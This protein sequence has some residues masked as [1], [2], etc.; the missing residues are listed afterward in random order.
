MKF[1]I[2][3]LALLAGISYA[4]AAELPSGKAQPTTGVDYIKVCSA[5]GEGFFTLP[6]SDTCVKISGLV[7]FE[8]QYAPTGDLYKVTSG[9]KAVANAGPGEASTGTTTT[10]I[11]GI[12]T[13]TPTELGDIRTV[14]DVKIVRVSGTAS[15]AGQ[16]SGATQSAS[17]TSTGS[18][19][20][21]YIQ[22][23]GFTGGIA[24]DNFK[25]MSRVGHYL[26]TP[27]WPSFSNG[28][29]Q[30][31]Y[32]ALFGGGFS[33][34]LA[35]Q[36]PS[37][38]NNAPID[39][40]TPTAP[41]IYNA[42][43]LPQVV[44]RLQLDQS[45]GRAAV[46]GAYN[47]QT[48]VNALNTYNATYNTWAVGS[49]LTFNLPMLAQGDNISFTANYA[50]G[51]TE[52]TLVSGSNKKPQWTRELNGW[53]MNPPSA[54]FYAGNDVGLV[55]SWAVGADLQHWWSPKWSSDI[56]ASYGTWVAPTKSAALVWDGK[57]G[58]GD[59]NIASVSGN[60]LWKP[61]KDF[62]IGAE[63]GY[64]R[65]TQDVRYTLASSTN[66]VNS[67]KDGNWTVRTMV[68]RKF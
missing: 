63:V 11:I 5:A 6:G 8:T 51:M 50:N 2:S 39:S 30:L 59:G 68:E 54:V 43:K 61:V 53:V 7:R 35:L 60:L 62:Q 12:D 24:G 20:N 48:A 3:M 26:G 37:D 66:L 44:G 1:G 32:T 40:I 10:G 47:Q 34:T 17:N 14:A 56:T 58:F 31:S 55:K 27:R 13:R 41:T 21:A 23:L 42:A 22:F 9:A 33:G 15:E 52:Y 64:S 36:N 18:T 65:I 46:M 4:G 19:E 16:P 38:T 45:W 67:E 29:T 49:G 28:V 57:A 25:Y